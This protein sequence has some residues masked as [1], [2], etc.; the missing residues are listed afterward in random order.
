[1][2]CEADTTYTPLAPHLKCII[3][4]IQ[5]IALGQS[6]KIAPNKQKTQKKADEHKNFKKHE[7]SEIL[8]NKQ[9]S[10]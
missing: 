3:F 6:R 10:K 1:M 2:I 8:F 5:S 9:V 4:Y 7:T